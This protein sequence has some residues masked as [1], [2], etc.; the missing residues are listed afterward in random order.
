MGPIWLIP[1]APLA[2]AAINGIFGKK[3]GKLTAAVAIAALCIA[4]GESF[5]VLA[6]VLGGARADAAFYSWI[7]VGKFQVSIGYLVDPL[8]V[9]MLLVVTGVSTLVHIYSVG[10][11]EHDHAFW[12]FF[13]YLPLFTFFMLVLVLANNFLQMF[14]GW[15]GVGLSSYLLIGFW[16]D[17]RSAVDAANKAFIVN[18]VGDFGFTVA[19]ILIWTT[20]GT[21]GFADVFKAAPSVSTALLTGITLLLFVGACGK[22]AQIPLYTWLPDAME[23]PTPVSALIHAATMVTAGVYMVA[24]CYPLFIHTPLTLSVVAW[25][26]AITAIF[27]ASIGLVQNDIKRVLAYSTVSQLGYMFLALGVVVPV[28]GI[29]HLFTH[30]FFKGLLFLG[31]G[32]VIHGMHDEQDLRKMGGLKRWMPWTRWTFLVACL[33]ISGIFPFAGFWSKDEILGG[34]FDGGHDVLYAVG[35]FTAGL[36][37]FYMFREYFL[38]FEG[39]PRFDP[40]HV[41]PHESSW[42]MVGPLVVLG[43][44]SVVVGAALGS[45]PDHGAL[46]NFL[47]PAFANSVHFGTYEGVSTQ[48]FILIGVSLLFALSGI[49]VAWQMYMSKAWSP[50]ALAARFSLV[51]QL[52]F[53]KW[54]VDEIYNVLFV[55]PTLA[56]ARFL[57]AFD[58]YVID[59]IVNGS[60]NLTR[61]VGR[62]LRKVQT[63][64][65]GNYAL[66][67]TLGLLAILGGFLVNSYLVTH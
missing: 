6:Q 27:A 51:Y 35:L 43:V 66:G 57:W 61:Y 46:F 38:V 31:A 18:R 34:A 26:G 9:I 45:P 39:T 1:V 16:Y 13:A 58:G 59:G 42:W 63:G 10:Y 29:F 11:M 37:A 19:V 54:Y 47:S 40:E 21:L 22:S 32:S 23:G 62:G 56:L 44:A 8:T 7:P 52:L 67:M 2:A 24:R 17:R 3:I 49:G 48:T 50:E 12:R 60:G 25:I 36:T 14:V 55:Q 5:Y 53:N 4:L 65:V 30:A 28:S 41:H 20:F 15:E 33:A 64:G